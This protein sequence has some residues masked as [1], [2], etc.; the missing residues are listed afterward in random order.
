[1]KD[2]FLLKEVK[3]KRMKRSKQIGSL[4]ETRT[5]KENNWPGLSLLSKF[6]LFGVFYLEERFR[7]AQ[8]I[9]DLLGICLF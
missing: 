2:F 1:M 7:T 3:C 9:F 6:K 4:K 5:A 8:L